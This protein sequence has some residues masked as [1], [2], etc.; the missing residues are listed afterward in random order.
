MSLP[1]RESD[2]AVRFRD[3]LHLQKVLDVVEGREKEKGIKCG[4]V[5]PDTLSGD[6]RTLR[7]QGAKGLDEP[8]HDAAY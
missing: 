4:L 5:S 1:W 8:S 2:P 7:G 6:R 3:P